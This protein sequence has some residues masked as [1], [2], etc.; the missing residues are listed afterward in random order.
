MLSTNFLLNMKVRS[1]DLGYKLKY[2]TDEL[3]ELITH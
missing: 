3:M 1:H 2:A